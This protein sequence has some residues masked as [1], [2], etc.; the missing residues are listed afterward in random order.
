[1]HK[2]LGSIPSNI[3]ERERERKKGRKRKGKGERKDCTYCNLEP[4][5]RLLP[6]MFEM[7]SVAG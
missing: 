3:R 4:C 5:S 2:T 1:M 6:E 7:S